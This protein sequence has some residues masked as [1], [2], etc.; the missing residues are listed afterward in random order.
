MRAVLV[1]DQRSCGAL[2]YHVE[3]GSVFIREIGMEIGLL[4]DLGLVGLGDRAAIGHDGSAA[5]DP[6]PNPSLLGLGVQAA[7]Q[8]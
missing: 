4:V 2:V 3:S 8:L 7:I 1:R 6:N 5:L